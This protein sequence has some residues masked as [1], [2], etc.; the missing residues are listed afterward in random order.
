[1]RLPL[2]GRYLAGLALSSIL[3]SVGY[4][5]SWDYLPHFI[6]TDAAVGGVPQLV[7]THGLDV[8][9][10][11]IIAANLLTGTVTFHQNPE[12]TILEWLVLIPSASRGTKGSPRAAIFS[13]ADGLTASSQPGIIVCTYDGLLCTWHPGSRI[14]RALT[15]V[16]HASLNARYVGLDMGWDNGEPRVY[17]VNINARQI[18]EYDSQWT[19][20]RAFRNE[21]LD[22]D[23][24]PTAIWVEGESI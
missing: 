21:R 6:C 10:E 4:G 20:V 18:E 16:N 17:V 9:A 12:A 24:T 2:F 3:G 23:Y 11:Q 14:N 8:N 22:P 1:M 5:Q 15:R 7:G 13:P 19:W